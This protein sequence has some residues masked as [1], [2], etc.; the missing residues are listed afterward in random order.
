MFALFFLAVSLSTTLR[1]D[2]I[3]PVPVNTPHWLSRHEGFLNSSPSAKIVFLG[4]SITDLWQQQG[5]EVWR[6]QIASLTALNF[7]IGGDRIEHLHWRILNGELDHVLPQV[8]VLLIGTNNL[9][10]NSAIEIELGYSSLLEEIRRRSPASR[11]I[12]INL[13]P[14]VD[15]GSEVFSFKIPLVNSSIE[16]LATTLRN[17]GVKVSHLSLDHEFLAAD[18]TLPKEIAFDGL[19]L[20]EKGYKIWANALIPL[21][22]L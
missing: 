11:L 12:L 15:P 2:P 6:K 21:L 20:T 4:D 22:K 18:G 1:A 5:R 3:V 7:G 8:I 19:H 17:S 16:R 14:R 10:H 9:R 13:F